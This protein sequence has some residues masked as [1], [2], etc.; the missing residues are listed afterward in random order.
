MSGPSQLVSAEYSASTPPS[1]TM[2]DDSSG[3]RMRR[4]RVSSTQSST[5]AMH[6]APSAASGSASQ[7][8]APCRAIQSASS[9]PAEK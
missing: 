1:V 6:P 5:T 2:S 9:A 3:A 4:S 7:M 8:E